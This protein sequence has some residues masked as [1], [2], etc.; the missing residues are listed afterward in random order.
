MIVRR[1]GWW[2]FNVPAVTFN[3]S[4]NIAFANCLASP[5]V[6]NDFVFTRIG[7]VGNVPPLFHSIETNQRLVMVVCLAMM[8]AVAALRHAKEFHVRSASAVI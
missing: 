2:G 5:S 4:D 3:P 8:A 7:S 1:L 6:G